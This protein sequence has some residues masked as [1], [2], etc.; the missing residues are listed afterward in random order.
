MSHVHFATDPSRP[1]MAASL[2]LHGWEVYHEDYISGNLETEE[3]WHWR[4]MR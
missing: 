4:F 3:E 1:L 2:Y